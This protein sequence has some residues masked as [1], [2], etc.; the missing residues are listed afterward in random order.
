M[1]S[2]QM[3]LV[4]KCSLHSCTH[5]CDCHISSKALEC[6]VTTMLQPPPIHIICVAMTT[7][8]SEHIS[9][10]LAYLIARGSS[11]AASTLNFSCTCSR[12]AVLSS[13]PLVGSATSIVRVVGVVSLEG[14]WH[15]L[16]SHVHTALTP[17]RLEPST[18]IPS[19]TCDY[20]ERC[21]CVCV[22]GEGGGEG[23]RGMK[24]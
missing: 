22:C 1:G 18:W 24:Y 2:V 7:A 17:L 11:L 3:S 12:D 5:K 15:S 14:D 9:T 6:E 16:S 13:S 23:V 21:V 10:D 19:S 4:S 8:T 20:N